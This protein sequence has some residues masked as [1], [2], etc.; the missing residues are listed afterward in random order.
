VNFDRLNSYKAPIRII[1]FLLTLLVLWLPIAAPMHLIFGE[2]VG[3]ALTILLYCEFLGL[4][5][6]WGRRVAKYAHPYRYYGL[7]FTANNGRD[8]LLGL[9]LGS[10]TLI[11]FFYLQVSFGW[12]AVQTVDWRVALPPRFLPAI[13]G[14]FV[15]WQGAILPGLLTSVG[16]GFAEEMLFRGWLL[17][18]LERDY[19]KKTA[20]ISA[21]LV[22][23][24]L[25]FIKPLNVILATWSQFVGL[26]I[27]SVALILARRRCDGRLG[28]AI[29]LHGGLVWCYYIVN[30]THWLKPTGAVPDWVT[31]INGNPIAGVMGIAFLSAIAIGFG[32]FKKI[33]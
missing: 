5:W 14:Y 11:V 25:H 29:G 10:A 17:S 6:I 31:G 16:V 32:G 1:I 24:I 23:A 15:D 28:I 27:L 19:S 9:G 3:V 2:S 12:L 18:E 13:G 8:F 22:F 30:T 21:S 20:L 4:I 26:A 33:I 7:S